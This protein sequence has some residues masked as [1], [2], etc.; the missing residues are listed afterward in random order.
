MEK[1]DY[2]S[3]RSQ[4]ESVLELHDLMF[5]VRDP[6]PSENLTD[7]TPNPIFP[8][9]R[10][11]DKL[12]TTWIKFTVAGSVQSMIASCKTSKESWDVWKNFYL[13]FAQ[14]LFGI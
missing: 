1:L 9:W 12:V 4:F 7:G 8:K 14:Y 2:M 10:K 6:P 5:T 11:V 13:H 3:W